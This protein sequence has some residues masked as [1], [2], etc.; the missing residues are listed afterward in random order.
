MQLYRVR[1]P[2]PSLF[3]YIFLYL[4]T[5]KHIILYILKWRFKFTS[6]LYIIM[7]K[8]D[9]IKLNS[10]AKQSKINKIYSLSGVQI[11]HM[12]FE[13]IYSPMPKLQKYS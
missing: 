8:F 10:F 11:I 12:L 1:N 3:N 9:L 6:L 7:L 5:Y 4:Y 13:S 2:T